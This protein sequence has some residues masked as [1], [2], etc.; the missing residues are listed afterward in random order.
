MKR[1]TGNEKRTNVSDKRTT[2]REKFIAHG[3]IKV[4]YKIPPEIH[5]FLS[6]LCYSTSVF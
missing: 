1:P 2:K 5:S 3:I 6:K 4:S